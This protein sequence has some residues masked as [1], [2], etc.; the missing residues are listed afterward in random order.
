MPEEYQPKSS[1]NSV[2]KAESGTLQLP[3]LTNPCAPAG[4]PFGKDSWPH[5]VFSLQSSADG[6]WRMRQ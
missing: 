5:L 2:Y 1:R 3:R 4:L 6:V